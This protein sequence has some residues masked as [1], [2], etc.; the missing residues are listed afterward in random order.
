MCIQHPALEQ[1]CLENCPYLKFRT[2]SESGGGGFCAGN[3]QEDWTGVAGFC[4]NNSW[5]TLPCESAYVR[6]YTLVLQVSHQVTV[7]LQVEV[8]YIL[9]NP[10][11]PPAEFIINISNIAFW[12][13]G[14]FCFLQNYLLEGLL[15]CQNPGIVHAD[16]YAD[17]SKATSP[18][19]PGKLALLAPWQAIP[20]ARMPAGLRLWKSLRSELWV[21]G[22]LGYWLKTVKETS[23]KSCS[24]CLKLACFFSGS[25]PLHSD[26]GKEANACHLEAVT[27]S[28]STL[29]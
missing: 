3:Q 16:S 27:P 19:L 24:L 12:A 10:Y 8:R 1:W 18:R 28:Q 20:A 17:W 11:A 25:L 4:K 5:Q 9:S 6:R 7:S 29:R 21:W 15:L 14:F 13:S 22:T 2:K 23:R 26:Q